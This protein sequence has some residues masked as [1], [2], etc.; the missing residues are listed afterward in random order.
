MQQVEIR[1]KGQ[2][3]ETWSEWFEGFSVTYTQC[4]E[5]I[6][7]GEVVDQSALYGVISKL[8]DLGLTLVS[9]NPQEQE[10]NN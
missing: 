7:S 8:R 9:V 10:E 6:L 1:I 5:T 2:I 4:N 3:D